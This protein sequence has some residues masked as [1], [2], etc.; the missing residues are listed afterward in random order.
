VAAF[1]T[2]I[3]SS[4]DLMRSRPPAR[5]VMRA[6]PPSVGFSLRYFSTISAMLIRASRAAVLLA[7]AVLL[8][9]LPAAAGAFFSQH[10]GPAAFPGAA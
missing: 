2:T 7:G 6:I 4:A 8:A 3:R 9:V 5:P 1:S 10:S